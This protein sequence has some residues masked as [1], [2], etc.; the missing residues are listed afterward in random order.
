MSGCGGSSDEP[1]IP[2]VATDVAT[3]EIYVP[4]PHVCAPPFEKDGQPSFTGNNLQPE[5]SVEPGLIFK[6]KVEHSQP[7]PHLNQL[8]HFE[9]NVFVSNSFDGFAVYGLDG[10]D[11]LRED[12]AKPDFKPGPRCTTIAMHEASKSLYC[13]A[14]DGLGPV[15]LEVG[16][17]NIARVDLTAPL[18][19]EL[20]DP[21]AVTGEALKT[22]QVAVYG[23]KLFMASL[24]Q[25]LWIA[26][27]AEDGGLS[28]LR[29]SGLG[30]DV[31]SVATSP[32]HLLIL[33]QEEG[34]IRIVEGA[35]G[36]TQTDVLVMDGPKLGLRI[37]GDR[38][39]VSLGSKGIAV[40][41]LSGEKFQLLHVLNPSGVSV[42]A[43]LN[44][45]ALAVA[46]LSGLYLYDLRPEKPRVAGFAPSTWVML[47]VL[48]VGES[49]VVSDWRG[50]LRYE[51]RLDGHVLTPDIP[52]DRYF[53]PGQDLKLKFRNPGDLKLYAILVLFGGTGAAISEIVQ[54][55][56]I[57]PGGTTE[58]ALSAEV[59]D[60][61]L[62]PLFRE[63][64][65][66]V[67]VNTL[68]DGDPCLIGAGDTL[69]VER[70]VEEGAD[71]AHPAQGQDMAVFAVSDEAQ[72]TRW[73]PKHGK[74][75]RVVFYAADCAAMWP[76]IEDLAWLH[77]ANQMPEERLPLFVSAE[78]PF[79]SGFVEQ[80]GY[81]DLNFGYFGEP[82][83]SVPDKVNEANQDFG[84]HLYDDGFALDDLRGGAEHP[85]D[86]VVDDTGVVLSV[87]R[88]YRG[89][90]GL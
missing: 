64:S 32:D 59:V 44:G 24:G 4:A 50:I 65:A 80:W 53:A 56:E 63:T 61:Y 87:E 7:G 74:H 37:A 20:V 70:W 38:A 25:G 55:F 81:G 28:D 21:H 31:R 2:D 41:D 42:A 88:L 12:L 30:G 1:V 27:I 85:T 19:P 5:L 72:Q 52:R 89:I 62:E 46:T 71:V 36:F 48:F 9:N 43:D 86:Y 6:A 78:N 8:L 11:G 34:L 68:P 76:E 67:Y 29:D 3:D 23:D 22:R 83:S 66:Y 69:L 49:L 13:A 15:A 90:W 75:Q 51:T 60:G 82:F 58:F 54:T 77:R 16:T 45:D 10:E 73:I 39:L 33:D 14:A 84:D 47:D 40:V 26:D 35:E 18:E 17:G 79:K 57:Q